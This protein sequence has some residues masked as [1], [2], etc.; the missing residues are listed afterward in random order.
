MKRNERG[1]LLIIIP[2]LIVLTGI[3]VSV[4]LNAK[5][6]VKLNDDSNYVLQKNN[7]NSQ[8]LFLL[9]DNKYISQD[10]YINNLTQTKRD[11]KI[12]TG[13]IVNTEKQKIDTEIVD[14]LIILK[15]ELEDSSFYEK[16]TKI[17]ID[18]IN[19]IDI[20]IELEEKIIH[21]GDSEN[22]DVKLM[23]AKT[24]LE[25]EKDTSGEIFVDDIS[26]CY[27]KEKI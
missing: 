16:I 15:D 3:G 20:Y 17:N 1:T 11:E 6:T 21:L 25:N 22:L 18:S 19:Q 12:L 8:I 7:E 27:F 26:N 4:V 23:Y 5:E 2:I 24:I 10:G 13:N 14:R 9:E